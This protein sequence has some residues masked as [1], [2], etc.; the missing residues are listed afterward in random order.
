MIEI[1]T[2]DGLGIPCQR[3]AKHRL[4]LGFSLAALS[5]FIALNPGRPTAVHHLLHHLLADLPAL[6]ARVETVGECVEEFIFFVKQGEKGPFRACKLH[7]LGQD[8]FSQ[9]PLLVNPLQLQE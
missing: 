5:P 1:N 2:A 3:D 9:N 4:R 6:P 7:G 8:P